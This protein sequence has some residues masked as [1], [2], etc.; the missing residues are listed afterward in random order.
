MSRFTGPRA[1][2]WSRRG[3]P[4]VRK[5]VWRAAVTAAFVAFGPGAVLASMAANNVVEYV[6][7]L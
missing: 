7:E 5:A 1:G 3:V 6:Y 2:S 4:A